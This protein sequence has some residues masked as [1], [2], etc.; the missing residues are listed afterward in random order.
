MNLLYPNGVSQQS[1]GLRVHSLP[2]VTSSKVFNFEEVVL[3]SNIRSQRQC[4]ILTKKALES[5]AVETPP[6]PTWLWPCRAKLFVVKTSPFP[7]KLEH[8][9]NPFLQN[10]QLARETLLLCQLP[11]PPR[12][13]VDVI[14]R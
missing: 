4:P 13:L 2:R 5:D 14:K 6:Y 10:L 11:Q 8:L 12:R 1:P 9:R 3:F 7:V